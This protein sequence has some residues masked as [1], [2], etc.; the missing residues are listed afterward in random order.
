MAKDI[1][2]DF[3][4]H[5]SIGIDSQISGFKK[6]HTVLPNNKKA[7][8]MFIASKNRLLIHKTT[9]ALWRVS[10]DGTQIEP[11]FDTDVLTEEELGDL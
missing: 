1:F 6:F 9:Q 8:S 3:V 5:S 10:E 11:V 4:W 7:R 2:S